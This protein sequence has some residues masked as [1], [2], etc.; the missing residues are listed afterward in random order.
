VVPPG[1]LLESMYSGPSCLSSRHCKAATSSGVK[2]VKFCFWTNGLGMAACCSPGLCF[3]S[4][5]KATCRIMYLLRHFEPLPE[6]GDGSCIFK[7]F[8]VTHLAQAER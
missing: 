7:S 3:V 5:N 6:S 2:E 8:K 4:I 1:P